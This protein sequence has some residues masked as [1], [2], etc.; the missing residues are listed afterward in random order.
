[1]REHGRVDG[2]GRHAG[3]GI[4]RVETVVVGGGQA[5][6]SVAYHLARRGRPFVV[7]DAG[8][9]VGDSW[10]T[11]WDSLRLF[12]PARYDS[13]PGW[14]FPASA[15]TFPTKDEMGEYLQAYARRFD[16]PVRSGV[17]VERLSP[18]GGRW[19]VE[20]AGRRLEADNVVIATG[21]YQSPRVPEFAEGLDPRIVQLHSSRYLNPSQLQPGPVLVVG[22]GNS[23]AD[24]ALDVAGGHRTWMAGRDVGHLPFRVSSLPSRLLLARIALR[25]VFHRVLTLDT[26][27]GR[28]ARPALTSRGGPLIRIRAK[29]LEAAAVERAPRMVGT[30]RGLPLLEDGRVLEVTNVVWCTGFRHDLAWA[31]LPEHGPEGA[32]LGRVVADRPGLYLVGQHFLHALSSGMVHGVERDAAFVA[33][34][35]AVRAGRPSD[36][37]HRRRRAAEHAQ[38][39]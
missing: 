23:G 21:A 38:A 14:A 37:R 15:W 16:L 3:N 25:V 9:R 28:K 4:E 31:G 2:D 11:R 6:L 8:E 35:I 7:L 22:A 1:M 20:A 34:A 24:I 19:V 30:E 32:S 29:D 27:I 26:P 17:K 36:Q 10:R 39:G 18:R 33:D 5:G 12:T 13:L